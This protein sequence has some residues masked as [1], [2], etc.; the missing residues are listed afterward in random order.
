MQ[1]KPSLGIIP[2]DD[3]GDI[4]SEPPNLQDPVMLHLLLET[5]TLTG[6][7]VDKNGYTLLT[8]NEVDEAKREISLTTKRITSL[9]KKLAMERKVQEAASNLC[10]LKDTGNRSTVSTPLSGTS[11]HARNQS[12]FMM[13]ALSSPSSM[14]S[15]SSVSTAHARNVSDASTLTSP[16]NAPFTPG[17]GE[18]DLVTSTRKCEHLTLQLYRQQALENDLRRRLLE[19][20]VEV[21]KA[22]VKASTEDVRDGDSSVN[23]GN[24]NKSIDHQHES[25]ERRTKAMIRRS[26]MVNHISEL[27]DD[28]PFLDQSHN[29]T[30]DQVDQSGEQSNDKNE[31]LVTEIER[32]LHSLNDQIHTVL[33]EHSSS[34]SSNGVHNELSHLEQG[35]DVLVQQQQQQQKKQPT[36][37]RD[38]NSTLGPD[39][40]H[41]YAINDRLSGFLASLNI[42]HPAGKD[43]A[44]ASTPLTIN[45]AHRALDA[46]EE[47]LTEVLSYQSTLMEQLISAD[48]EKK[49]LR[50]GRDDAKEKLSLQEAQIEEHKTALAQCK[51]ENE[52]LSQASLGESRTE[53]EAKIKSLEKELQELSDEK[54]E[55]AGEFEE[56]QE[57]LNC[58]DKEMA[59]LQ[60]ELTI[61]RAE[62]DTHIGKKGSADKERAIAQLE[63][64]IN[65]ANEGNTHL[66]DRLGL[67]KTELRSVI[68]DFST[69]LSECVDS[70]RG[71]LALEKELDGLNDKCEA[72]ENRLSYEKMKTTLANSDTNDGSQQTPNSNSGTSVLMEQF[73]KIIR[74]T[75][76]ENKKIVEVKCFALINF[77]VSPF[78]AVA[79]LHQ[80]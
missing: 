52:Q 65:G 2:N 51:A 22:A 42:P 15:L 37:V 23:G 58:V 31:A 12:G 48:I 60:T 55:L 44:S 41:L 3:D 63:E 76:A 75:R 78:P 1:F 40:Y 34:S 49:S 27:G 10:R 26:I 11:G 61:S 54:D 29:P 30:V 18:G 20:T 5:A 59:R 79:Y 32:R 6:T 74:D 33:S 25:S 16:R 50:E 71:K 43:A 45:S 67:I 46:L 72:L 53:Y 35:L 7:G 56:Q 19:H 38:E 77:G 21:L 24:H 14:S 8:L 62:L 13:S 66:M 64:Q 47:H 28:S 57:Y 4:R 68:N 69:V 73:R 36:P 39:E 17:P 80:S 70:E 9:R